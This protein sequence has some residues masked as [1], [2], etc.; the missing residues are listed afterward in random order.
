M[1][2]STMQGG[3]GMYG[4]SMY[5]GG[6][7]SSMY[8][9]GMMCGSSL[10]NQ[11]IPGQPGAH[12]NNQQSNQ[13]HY[14]Q[15]SIRTVLRFVTECA[16]ILQGFALVFTTVSSWLQSQTGGEGQPPGPLKMFYEGFKEKVLGL[17]FSR[18]CSFFDESISFSNVNTIAIVFLIFLA[19]SATNLFQLIGLPPGRKTPALLAILVIGR[20][21]F[22]LSLSAK[23]L[24]KQVEGIGNFG[25][26][27]FIL[28]TVFLAK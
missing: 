16:A 14:P 28:D 7:G 2:G 26:W 15:L 17:F 20:T 25:S 8:G 6:Y 10:T 18:L 9:G 21:N 23:Q 11:G 12:P 3:G 19:T 22:V 1:Y 13:I 27:A 24:K 5:G 4:S